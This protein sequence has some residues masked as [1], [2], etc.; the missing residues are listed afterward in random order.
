MFGFIIREFQEE[1]GE[2]IKSL[3]PFALRLVEVAAVSIGDEVQLVNQGLFQGLVSGD[4][5]LFLLLPGLDH[6]LVT[7][8]S[9]PHLCYRLFWLRYLLVLWL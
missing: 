9:L 1:L 8:L 5:P 4:L 2:G 6:L 7:L 3:G